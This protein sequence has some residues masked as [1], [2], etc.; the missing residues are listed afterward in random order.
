MQE[1]SG[2]APTGVSDAG[3]WRALL[4]ADATPAD[5]YAL[6]AHDETDEDLSEA[7]ERMW[8]LG[9]QRWSRPVLNKS[10]RP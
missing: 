6:E 1:C 2:L 4:G 3:T 10:M 7:G 8:M 5:A 9:E